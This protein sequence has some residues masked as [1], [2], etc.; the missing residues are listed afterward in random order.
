MISVRACSI[1]P[2]VALI[3][4]RLVLAQASAEDL[5]AAERAFVASK[6]YSS[7]EIFFAHRAGVAGLDLDATYKAYLAKA[8]GAKGRREFDL[9]TLE[10]VA[11]LRNKHTQFDDQWLRRRYGQPLGFSAAP[12]E[13]KWV[14][15]S[16]GDSRMKNGSVIQAVD[17]TE[18]EAY[19]RDKQRYI[20]ASS[21]RGA[22]SLVFDR[23]YLFP[24]SFTLELEGG[25]LI[26]IERRDAPRISARDGPSRTS[27]GHWLSEGAVGYIKIPAFNDPKFERTAIDF[28]RRFRNAKAL[29]IDVRGNGGGSTPYDL[30]GELMDR[31][32]RDW[33]TS[34][35]VQV[36]IDRA[37]GAPLA[38]RRTE[39][40]RSQ[41]RKEAFTGRLLLLVD[42]FT[43][44]ACED[45]VMPFKDNGRAEIIGEAT[46]G[47]SGQ[48]FFFDFGNGMSFLVG[49]A[50]HT[51]PDGSSFESVGI[52][53]TIPVERHIAD[54]KNGVDPVLVRAKELAGAP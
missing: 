17:G 54:V 33:S 14:I 42:R 15:T 38:Q 13:G 4:I 31:E 24:Q 39:S 32:W 11:L 29:I 3:V 20:S 16:T 2:I 37:R 36:A 45:F 18:V 49:A 53:P 44:S 43:C 51:F 12:V 40:R 22:R 19:V 47:S 9:A 46:E 26:S 50:R 23:P 48:P 7:I 41:P 21:E 25:D 35:P 10:F 6:I 28:A 27:E 30:I 8:L 34:T 5:P 1:A 52:T